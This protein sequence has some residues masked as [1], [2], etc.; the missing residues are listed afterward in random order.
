MKESKEKEISNS[1]LKKNKNHNIDISK[2][3][4]HLLDKIKKIN[5]SIPGIDKSISHTMKDLNMDTWAD[6]LLNEEIKLSKKSL[7]D[8]L[9]I[10]K[11]GKNVIFKKLS[12]AYTEDK[13]VFV[14]G[15]GVSIDFAVPSWN[16]LLQKLMV[17][18]IDNKDSESMSLMFNKLFSPNPLISGRY[19]QNNI[20]ESQ[21]SFEQS[22]RE[23]LYTNVDKSIESKLFDEIVHYCAAPGKSPN[24]DSIITYNFDDILEERISKIKI[25]VPFRSIFGVGMHFNNGE[26]PIYHVHGYLPEKGKLGKNNNITLGEDIYHQ[27]YTDIYSWN[28]IVQINKF[29]DNTCLFIGTSLTDPNMRRLLD[30]AHKQ[31]GDSKNS[32]Y[33]FR[34]RENIEQIKEKFSELLKENNNTVDNKLLSENNKSKIDKTI[35]FMKEMYEGFIEKDFESFGVKTIW[36]NSYDEIPEYLNNI[37]T[38]SH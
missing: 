30:I 1:L 35:L 8:T 19:L 20:N 22:V 13:L 31:K 6:F 32:H 14:L 28:N 9:S 24:L 17:L 16:D 29:R 7:Q 34:E 11:T 25:K 23:A 4:N 36:L 33:I 2:I 37:R 27:Q 38:K 26:L 10:S 18:T 5:I 12:Q 3:D 21:K 15:A